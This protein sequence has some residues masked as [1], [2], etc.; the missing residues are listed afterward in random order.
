MTKR[1]IRSVTGNKV[2]TQI[3]HCGE[4]DVKLGKISCAYDMKDF[5]DHL[6]SAVNIA[7]TYRDDINQW[8]E[9]R[10]VSSIISNERHSKAMPEE[11][12][13]KWNIGLP[14]TAKD[15][16][17][18]MTQHGIRT[19]IHPMMRRVPVDHLNLH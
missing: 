1:Q 19:A 13:S 8:N 12:A 6:I 10:R 3:K 17:R 5:C 18:V 11:L 7:M 15:T 14:Q 16:I 2:R 9:E 4:M